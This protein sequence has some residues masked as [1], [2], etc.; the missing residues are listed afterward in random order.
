MKHKPQWEKQTLALRDE[1]TWKAPPG[2]NVF[3]ADRGAVRFN[4]PQD[5]VIEPA[6]DCIALY[7]QK[8]PQDNCRLAVSYLR[9]PP[10]DWSGLPLAQLITS[11]VKDDRRKVL[12]RGEITSIS[13]LDVELAWMEIRFLDPQE[14]REAFS[15]IALARGSNL[16][17]LITCDYWPEDAKR[18]E[19]IWDEV[20]RSIELG[21]YVTDPTAGDVLH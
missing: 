9:L 10:V 5:W 7:D 20:L 18:L 6:S 14:K 11:V 3:V 1:H 12:A 19:P 15:R 8:P 2:Y 4:L 16:Q 21:R 17:A 13:R